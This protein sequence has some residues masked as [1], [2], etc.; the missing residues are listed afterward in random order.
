MPA[1]TK[2]NLIDSF[3]TSEW[4]EVQNESEG[5]QKTYDESLYCGRVRGPMFLV[6]GVSLNNRFYSE[7]L[8]QTCIRNNSERFGDAKGLH[9][10]C[11]HERPLN[12]DSIATGMISHK[13]TRLWID[14]RTKTGMGEILILNNE[15]GRNLALCL[16][17]GMAVSVSSRAYGR[18]TGEKGPDGKSDVIDPSTYFLETFDFVVNPGVAIATPPI[19]ESVQLQPT[20]EDQKMELKDLLSLNERLNGEKTQ[21]QMEL[22]EALKINEEATKKLSSHRRVFESVKRLTGSPDPVRS[23]TAVRE[24]LM[25][26]LAISPFDQIAKEYGILDLPGTSMEEITKQLGVVSE[27]YAKLGTPDKLA[28]DQAELAE[29]RKLGS[30]PAKMQE[31][32]KL[33]RAYINVCERKRP[34][35]V[36]KTLAEANKV[37]ALYRKLQRKN[38]AAKLATE[39]KESK[40]FVAGLLD[41]GMKAEDIKALIGKRNESNNTTRNLTQGAGNQPLKLATNAT[42]SDDKRRPGARRVGNLFESIKQSDAPELTLADLNRSAK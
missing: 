16:R 30:S 7:E 4:S 28:A 42:Q 36:K 12:E 15:A 21:V 2:F 6:D 23:L 41:K 25:K 18:S 37:V 35:Q 11:G 26:W 40:E 19:V 27:K 10:V 17:T 1:A 39:L 9:G 5:G 29:W 33:L 13:V 38:E 3:R 34:E 24:G 14:P 8:W 20:N 22:K 32:L 31:G